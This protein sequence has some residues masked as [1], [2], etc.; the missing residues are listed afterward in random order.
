MNRPRAI[1][2]T[3]KNIINKLKKEEEKR[4][5]KERSRRGAKAKLITPLF[6]Y[7]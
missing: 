6:R 3:P 7:I 2:G 4:E 1:E 5:G